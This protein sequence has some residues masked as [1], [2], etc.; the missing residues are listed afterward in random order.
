VSLGNYGKF[1]LSCNGGNVVAHAR[2]VSPVS[3]G[4]ASGDVCGHGND[5][6]GDVDDG[7]VGRGDGA[8]NAVVEEDDGGDDDGDD[9]D[10]DDDVDG[11]DD[12]ANDTVDDDFDFGAGGKGMGKLSGAVLDTLGIMRDGLIVGKLA[13]TY[14]VLVTFVGVYGVKLRGEGRGGELAD[15]GT[16]FAAGLTIP[17]AAAEGFLGEVRGEGG[18]ALPAD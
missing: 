9:D 2:P 10:G 14:V 12:V 16:G 17:F 18:C 13:I 15:N 4:N 8:G 1:V 3:S 6:A 5:Y 7:E 11:G